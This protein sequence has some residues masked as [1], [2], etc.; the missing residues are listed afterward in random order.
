MT[1]DLRA[2][3]FC[4]PNFIS[5]MKDYVKGYFVRCC[6]AKIDATHWVEGLSG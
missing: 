5:A 1:S 2:H 4:K 6:K 3:K